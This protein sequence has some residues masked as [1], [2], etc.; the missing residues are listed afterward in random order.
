MDRASFD[1]AARQDRGP[2][3]FAD[4]KNNSI[5]LSE[6]DFD[7]LCRVHLCDWLEQ[8]PRSKQW[9]Y[10]FEAYKHLAER[11]GGVA[12]EAYDAVYANVPEEACQPTTE[13][14]LS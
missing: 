12:Q 11:L 6:V 8:V 14:R 13:L 9:G 5:T 7:D 3:E 4:R 1:R 2:Y 10:R